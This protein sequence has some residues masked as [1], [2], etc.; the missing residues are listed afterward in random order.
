M[1]T[2][3]KLL[4]APLLLLCVLAQAQVKTN[5]FTQKQIPEIEINPFVRFD[6]YPQYSYHYSGRYS[7][8]Y[9]KMNGIS[10]GI[11]VSYKH[12][13]KKHLFIKAGF[14]YYKYKFDKLSNTNSLTGKS[15]VRPINFISPLFIMYSTNKYHYNN[16]MFRVGIGKEFNLNREFLIAASFHLSA[17]Y[18]ISQYY[19]LAANPW[20]GN[21][22]FNKKNTIFFGFSGAI[23]TSIT[24]QF[25]RLQIGPSLILPIYDTRLKDPVFLEES[26]TG[27]KNKW[28]NGIGVGIACN[29]S[30]NK[31]N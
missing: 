28:F 1:K 8:D 20:D 9:L 22:N 7:T 27:G 10:Y 23:S 5:Y 14:G 19:H 21:L 15:H 16:L 13:L 6:N 11:S 31:K 4:T 3:L 18:T 2:I 29:I 26:H 17:Y 24:K 12:P 25:N 30:L